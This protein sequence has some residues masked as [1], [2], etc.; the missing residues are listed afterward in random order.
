VPFEHHGLDELVV[1]QVRMGG[2]QRQ[3]A[4]VVLQAGQPVR[5]LVFMVVVD[6]R[7][8]G[9][10][11]AFGVA[12]FLRPGQV[13][14]QHVAHG[15][16]AVAVAELRDPVVELVGQVVVD[17]DSESPCRGLYSR[18]STQS[19]ARSLLISAIDRLALATNSSGRT[20]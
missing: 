13:L 9:H 5:Q 20:D 17:R 10:A 1:V 4:V 16:G 8:I 18:R 3:V 11:G 6:I 15:F 19:S 12:L 2:C 7:E 14:A